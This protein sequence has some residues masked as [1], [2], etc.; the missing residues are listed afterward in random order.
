[1]E[2]KFGNILSVCSNNL[3]SN[4]EKQIFGHVVWGHTG[5]HDQNWPKESKKYFYF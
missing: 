2:R 3:V 5:D 1:M 4:T